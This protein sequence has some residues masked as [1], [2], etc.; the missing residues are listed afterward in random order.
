MSG[1]EKHSLRSKCLVRYHGLDGES[2]LLKEKIRRWYEKGQHSRK[3]KCHGAK[4]NQAGS[5]D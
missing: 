5:F 1:Y 2:T 4:A 3:A